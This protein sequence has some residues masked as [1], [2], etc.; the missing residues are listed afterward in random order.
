MGKRIKELVEVRK[1]NENIIIGED[2]NI[3]IGEL[4]G[5]EMKEGGIETKNKDKTIS[6]EENKFVECI[7]KKDGIYVMRQQKEIGRGNIRMWGYKEIQ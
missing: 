7:Q 6:G 2:F 5:I 3:R 1:E 4:G